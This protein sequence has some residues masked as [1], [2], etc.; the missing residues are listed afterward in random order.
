[1]V[2]S[3]LCE[4]RSIYPHI[5]VAVVLAYMPTEATAKKYGAD[6]IF[7]E[8]IETAPKRYAIF[9]RNKWLTEQAQYVVTYITRPFGGAAQFA[10]LARSRGKRVLDVL[11][12]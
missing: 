11:E 8:G 7:P 1:M 4:L 5:S 9:W 10:E 6:T 3:V 2:Y 12:K